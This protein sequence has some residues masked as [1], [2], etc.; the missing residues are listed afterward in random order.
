[1]Y[2]E[3]FT[4]AEYHCR[5]SLWFVVVVVVAGPIVTVAVVTLRRLWWRWIVLP[6][7]WS[8]PRLY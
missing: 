4:Y 2:R 1:M 8:L 7:R 5:I 6:G 3:E